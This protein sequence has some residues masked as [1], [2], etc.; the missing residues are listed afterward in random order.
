MSFW[1]FKWCN[2]LDLNQWPPPS[3]G[4]VLI[5]LN[6]GCIYFGCV[7][8]IYFSQ[9]ASLIAPWHPIK[10]KSLEIRHR[11]GEKV[12]LFPFFEEASFV[13]DPESDKCICIFAGEFFLRKRFFVLHIAG[14]LLIWHVESWLFVLVARIWNSRLLF[15]FREFASG[16]LFFDDTRFESVGIGHCLESWI[17]C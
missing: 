15:P 1:F 17:W 10:V 9:N 16:G 12:F 4:G 6:Y 2:R 7:D 11:F 8:C 14:S 13:D 3:Q 5:Q